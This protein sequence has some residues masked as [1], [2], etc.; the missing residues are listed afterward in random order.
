MILLSA[1]RRVIAKYTAEPLASIPSDNEKIAYGSIKVDKISFLY[2]MI[3]VKDL[4]DLVESDN[5]ISMEAIGQV[6]T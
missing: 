2:D 1:L 5:P 6:I 4:V 3:G